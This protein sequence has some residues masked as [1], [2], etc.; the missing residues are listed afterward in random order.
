MSTS[1]GYDMGDQGHWKA[2]GD[3]ELGLDAYDEPKPAVLCRRTSTGRELKKVPAALKG[4]PH[5]AGLTALADW[6][7]D[8]AEEARARVE[9][10]M[11]QSLPVPA[12]LI[13]QVWPD[14]YWRRALRLAVLA[15]YEDGA[16]DTARAGLLLDAPAHGGLALTGLDGDLGVSDTTV[17][18]LHP[19][20]LDPR[21]TG[22]LAKWRELLDRFGGEQRIEQLRRAVFVRPDSSP[23]PHPHVQR[24]QIRAFDGVE[25]D[26]GAR[27]ERVVSRFGGR[28]AGE[29]ARFGFSERGQG[30]G[31]TLDLR[32]QGPFS[33]VNVHDFWWTR[34][35]GRF[36]PGAFDAIP[37]VVWSEGLRAMA[38]VYDE[39]SPDETTRSGGRDVPPDAHSAYQA[40]LVECAEY[41]RSAEP[42]PPQPAP[43]PATDGQ[44]L[45]VGA[46]LAGEP[47]GGR[48]EETMTA[49]TYGWDA[50]DDGQY[51]VR[52][53]PERAG[54]AE[55][56]VARALGLDPGVG[57]AAVVGRVRTAPLSFLS[58]ACRAHPEHAARAV[59]LLAPL[60]RCEEQAVAKPGRA[61]TQLR[62]NLVKLTADAPQLLPYALDEGARVVAGAG[63][64]AMAKPLFAAAREAELSS[65]RAPD[66]DELAARMA[67]FTTLGVITDKMLKEYRKGL[68]TRLPA[69]QADRRFRD[70]VLTWCRSGRTT[71]ATFAVELAGPAGAPLPDD[72]EHAELV[73]GLL[74]GHA[75]DETPPKVWQSWLPPLRRALAREP[76]LALVVLPLPPQ[77]R[78]NSPAGLARAAETWLD[79]L[80]ASGILDRITAAPGADPLPVETAQQWLDLVLR[81]YAGAAVPV[82]RLDEV[83]RAVARRTREAG[84]EREPLRALAARVMKWP[85]PAAV[86]LGMLASL[87]RAGM[88]T[89]PWPEDAYLGVSQWLERRDAAVAEELL[90]LPWFARRVR[91]ELVV[92]VDAEPGSSPGTHPLAK[93]PF[94]AG[95]LLRSERLRGVVLPELDRWARTL[96]EEAEDGAG[97]GGAGRLRVLLAL[98]VHAEAFAAPIEGN[99]AAEAVRVARDTDPV[100]LLAEE[101]RR[102][103]AVDMT[104]ERAAALLAAVEEREALALA[105]DTRRLI[106]GN[107][108]VAGG[109]TARGSGAWGGLRALVGR[110]LPELV[111]TGP[112]GAEA[113]G[114]GGAVEPG[115]GTAASTGPEGEAGSGG[116]GGDAGAGWDRAVVAV[117]DAVQC[118]TRQEKLRPSPG[119]PGPAR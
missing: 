89:A 113:T 15:P 30:F 20:L 80:D 51:V 38:A 28:I 47:V 88:P 67:E 71:P 65:G 101:L 29:Q 5:L 45:G 73:A 86:E 25:Y 79:L 34:T 11:T 107:V 68:T 90:D 42:C 57:P 40:F 24:L 50:L 62:D 44:L 17:A 94:A 97:E 119:E 56:A 91:A 18:V 104:P 115:P 70:L 12:E 36:G 58:Q 64:P 3:Y 116:A 7:G 99:P 31:L 1:R 118:R 26:S 55:D 37:H 75:F 13:R 66:E 92:P 53:V 106:G 114:S 43:E 46:V 78:G 59:A 69:E 85:W 117:Y 32:Y 23:A 61:A 96:A 52:L 95:R 33:G 60:R 102:C 41:G 98:L 10:W 100:P 105:Y 22:R 110:A 108:S 103:G 27:F 4:D 81:T 49:R 93:L 8:H 48:P 77:H 21:G 112:G 16:P 39:R 82:P 74:R 54:T 109:E 19:A 14:P 83:L 111:E 2:V 9:H 6:I 76:E 87:V 84:L 63:S 35:R 72:D